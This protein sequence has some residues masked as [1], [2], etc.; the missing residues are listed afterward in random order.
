M[1]FQSDWQL[2]VYFPSKTFS[3]TWPARRKFGTAMMYTPFVDVGLSVWVV[4]RC[5]F[6]CVGLQ[7]EVCGSVSVGG[8]RRGG[9]VVGCGSGSEEE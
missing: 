4:R 7:V 3:T 9:V 1:R 2:P 5:G 8:G 6:V